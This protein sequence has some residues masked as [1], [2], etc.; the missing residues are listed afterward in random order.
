MNTLK[1][2]Y[3]TEHEEKTLIAIGNC[4][5]EIEKNAIERIGYNKF[6][7]LKEFKWIERYSGSSIRYFYALE[8]EDFNRYNALGT[9]PDGYELCEEEGKFDLY[10]YTVMVYNN[11]HGWINKTNIYRTK[12]RIYAKRLKGNQ[13]SYIID[14]QK[15]VKINKG[16]SY[17]PND[18]F[19]TFEEAREKLVARLEMIAIDAHENYIFWSEKAKEEDLV[20]L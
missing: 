18:E 17:R 15:I 7:L 19:D 12:G 13:Y 16:A 3:T 4:S 6:Y 20:E 11:D 8:E 14:D 5:E 9:V 2:L 10:K 1:E